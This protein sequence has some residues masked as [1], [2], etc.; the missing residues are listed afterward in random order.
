MK[1]RTVAVATNLEIFD[2]SLLE[3]PVVARGDH[4]DVGGDIEAFHAHA[5][6]FE[7]SGN[8]LA[9]CLHV[10]KAA[11]VCNQHAP[12][13]DLLQ[14]VGNTAANLDSSGVAD[15]TLTFPPLPMGLL[16]ITFDHAFVAFDQPVNVIVFASNPV[17]FAFA[18]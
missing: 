13:L 17:A 5:H 1:S 15:A 3:S 14:Q 11:A 8:T 2:D 4:A 7:K 12:G 18:P 9:G 6:C 16:G 10:M